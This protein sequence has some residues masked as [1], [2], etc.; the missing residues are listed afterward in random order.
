MNKR[1]IGKSFLATRVPSL[2]HEIGSTVWTRAHSKSRS[3]IWLMN[4]HSSFMLV[5]FKIHDM[6]SRSR[7]NL[8]SES[9]MYG[10]SAP[11]KLPLFR[12]LITLDWSAWSL[13]I[14]ENS[15]SICPVCSWIVRLGE[16]KTFRILNFSSSTSWVL[17]QISK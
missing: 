11:I 13:I 7:L 17:K 16:P 10:L 4:S 8:L 6:I 5:C 14:R 1:G 2:G 12:P 9:N 15:L 3:L